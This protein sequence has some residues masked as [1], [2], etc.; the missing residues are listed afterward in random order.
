MRITFKSWLAALA[1]SW[2][3]CAITVV[4]EPATS[5]ATAAPGSRRWI[6]G[7]S[8]LHA[9]ESQAEEFDVRVG[10]E[11]GN[12]IADQIRAGKMSELTVRVSVPGLRSGKAQLDKRLRKALDAE[13]NPE[14]TFTMRS[15][16]V[17]ASSSADS[18]PIAVKGDLSVAGRARPIELQADVIGKRETRVRGA[19]DVL[20]TDHG[21][22]PPSFMGAIKTADRV[23]VNFDLTLK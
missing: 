8:S 6:A 15:Y 11:P 22:K 20:M 17:L 7:D 18:F 5:T 3:F 13:A 12:A 19:E 9:Y 1:L 16:E 4:A 10:I 21:V 23:V 2:A 14:I